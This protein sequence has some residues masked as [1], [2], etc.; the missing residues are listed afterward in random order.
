MEIVVCS[1]VYAQ[2]VGRFIEGYAVPHIVMDS[3]VDKG[4]VV[5]KPEGYGNSAV[6]DN[7]VLYRIVVL[8]IDFQPFIGP[9]SCEGMS[10]AVEYFIIEIGRVVDASA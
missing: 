8:S 3:I 4:A 2:V 10:L 7:A 1:I 6:E 5:G 9:V